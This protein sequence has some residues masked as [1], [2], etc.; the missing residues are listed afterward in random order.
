[1]SI[2]KQDMERLKDGTFDLSEVSDHDLDTLAL[3]TR[4]PF[5][6]KELC[7]GAYKRVDAERLRRGQQRY[8]DTHPEPDAGAVT[9]KDS[10]QVD[11]E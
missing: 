3:E 9:Q 8:R 4:A 2:T 5:F 7:D 10:A 1:M 6:D 11:H